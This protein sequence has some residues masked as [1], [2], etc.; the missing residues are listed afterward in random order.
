MAE[1]MLPDFA[2]PSMLAIEDNL[3]CSYDLFSPLLLLVFYCQLLHYLGSRA[4]RRGEFWIAC[5][6]CDRWFDGKCVNMTEKKAE[7]AKDWKCPFC[8]KGA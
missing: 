5:D 1:E 4:C 3:C 7:A 2:G 6:Y 8:M